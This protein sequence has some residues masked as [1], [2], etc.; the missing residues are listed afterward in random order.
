MTEK[1]ILTEL[2]ELTLHIQNT[3]Y[4]FMSYDFDRKYDDMSGVSNGGL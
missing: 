4:M 2:Y 1:S 3:E